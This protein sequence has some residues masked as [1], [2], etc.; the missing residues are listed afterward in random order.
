ML[1]YFAKFKKRCNSRNESVPFTVKQL[2]AN[3]KKL[4]AECKRVALT[5]KTSTVVKQFQEDRGYFYN[6]P[7]L[8]FTSNK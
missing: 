5:M 8:K 7:L 4:V 2:R 3:L 1:R 6:A